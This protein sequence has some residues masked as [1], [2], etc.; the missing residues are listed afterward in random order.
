MGFT[1]FNDPPGDAHVK[2][3][4]GLRVTWK[5]QA[6]DHLDEDSVFDV[7]QLVVSFRILKTGV[8]TGLLWETIFDGYPELA[9][10]DG[11][12]DAKCES[13]DIDQPFDD[14]TL[15]RIKDGEVGVEFLPE[16]TLA[17]E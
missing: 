5:I 16:E 3:G 8:A 2:A 11:V 17:H 9:W 1:A 6:Y 10:R 14:L 4:E 13:L 7:R 12:G 15:Q